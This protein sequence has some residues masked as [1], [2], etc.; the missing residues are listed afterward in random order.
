MLNILKDNYDSLTQ[1]EIGD[2]IGVSQRCISYKANQLG[3]K[4]TRKYTKITSDMRIYLL[5]NAQ[6]L[7]ADELSQKTGLSKATVQK[8][9]EDNNIKYVGKPK[10]PKHRK[11]KVVQKEVK[12]F[13]AKK[14]LN[15]MNKKEVVKSSRSREVIYDHICCNCRHATNTPVGYCSWADRLKPINGWKT[16]NK[17]MIGRQVMIHGK[18]IS[19]QTQAFNVVKCPLFHKDEK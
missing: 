2:M 1:T 11:K 17:G 6:Y 7:T 13:K 10:L 18:L 16:V 8:F 9:R 5:G 4:R 14:L 12:L 3:L 15:S 19:V